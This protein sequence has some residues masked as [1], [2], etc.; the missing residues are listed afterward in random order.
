MP[1]WGNKNQP[2]TANL[3]TVVESTEGAPIGTYVYVKGD[4]IDRKGSANAHAGNTVPSSRA[5]TDFDMFESSIFNEFQPTM[6]VGVYGVYANSPDLGA[7]RNKEYHDAVNRLYAR[8]KAGNPDGEQIK[9]RLLDSGCGYSG[10]VVRRPVPVTLY[11]ANGYVVSN[12]VH[13]DIYINTRVDPPDPMNGKISGFT[14]DQELF[15]DEPPNADIAPPEDF[16]IDMNDTQLF[17]RGFYI[18]SAQW[19]FGKGDKVYYY[20]PQGNTPA[21]PL[22]GNTY[23]YISNV[24]LSF[25][26]FSETP[27][28]PSIVITDPRINSDDPV[29]EQHSVQGRQALIEAYIETANNIGASHAGWVLR[30]EF[31]GGRE[32]RVQ[33][34]CLV[35]MSSLE[36]GVIP[37]GE[38]EPVVYDITPDF[39]TEFGGDLVAI[40]GENFISFDP[41]QVTETSLGNTYLTRVLFGNVFA[42]NVNVVN[43]TYLDC[44]SPPSPKPQTLDVR[45]QTGYGISRAGPNSKFTYTITEPYVKNVIPNRGGYKGQTNV[46]IAGFNFGSATAVKFGTNDALSFEV[47]S[48][49]Y[50]KAISPP[51]SNG[52]I[53]VLITGANG[54]SDPDPTSE[55]TY[56]SATPIVDRID[57]TSGPMD[58]VICT[59]YGSNF[60]QYGAQYKGD[61]PELKVYFG[62]Q[63]ANITTIVSDSQIVVDPPI[64]LTPGP[65]DVIVRNTY[66]NSIPNANSKFTYFAEAPSVTNCSPKQVSSLIATDVTV[67]GNNLWL[68]TSVRYGIY[69]G[70]NI[71]VAPDG[72]SLVFATVVDPNS[73]MYMPIVVDTPSGSSPEVYDCGINTI[74]FPFITDMDTHAWDYRGGK[75]VTITGIN[76][77]NPSF[78]IENVYVQKDGTG[79]FSTKYYANTSTII[80]SNNT[81]MKVNLPSIAAG[82]DFFTNYNLIL[83]SNN[84][85]LSTNTAGCRIYYDNW[86]PQINIVDPKIGPIKGFTEIY[87]YGRNFAQSVLSYAQW[88]EGPSGLACKSIKV[89]NNEVMIA[90]AE[91][92]NTSFVGATNHIVVLSPAFGWSSLNTDNIFGYTNNSGTLATLTLNFKGSGY[93]S[94]RPIKI[95]ARLFSNGM[96]DN[97]AGIATCEDFEANPNHG[98]IKTVTA[99]SQFPVLFRGF[100]NQP[101]ITI[102][103]P[104]K[105]SFP[106]NTTG[107]GGWPSSDRFFYLYGSNKIWSNGDK[108]LYSCIGP[109]GPL[110][111]LTNMTYYYITQVNQFDQYKFKLA[112]T[113]ADAMANVAI[114]IFDSR[115]SQQIPTND[116]SFVQGETANL[117]YTLVP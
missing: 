43:N 72:K 54:T 74:N 23:Y 25:I 22:T 8:D 14:V 93:N 100:D 81:N 96:I 20:V 83:Q 21:A 62:Q 80:L 76:F 5:R 102:D 115:I 24:D 19:N 77:N 92:V 85:L 56:Y 42:S 3:T 65:V 41:D 104:E 33:T 82:G 4:Q 29:P 68:A 84:N 117:T 53:N 9:Y 61:T 70:N 34:E 26:E 98:K 38:P 46:V 111:P 99:N 112:E 44:I 107:F 30:R 13:G 51:G 39:G 95:T 63:E 2:V 31:R 47:V 87:C 58:P 79:P 27:D 1:L 60:I 66:G 11:F 59:V 110:K 6:A 40:N 113:Y 67:Y 45:V 114:N 57:P 105:Y 94:N 48:N 109:G 71:R 15:A 50:I 28:G 78:K 35:A 10:G 75:Q 18:N 7:A 32:G 37:P 12:A 52:T 89:V 55:F 36:E 88:G 106:A 49:E 90:V 73:N 64:V 101:S 97:R 91:T 86:T 103:D 17:S 16:L 108:V 69:R 116:I